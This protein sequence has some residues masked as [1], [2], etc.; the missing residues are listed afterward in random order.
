MAI[1]GYNNNI[2]IIKSAR[3]PSTHKFINNEVNLFSST[4]MYF[5]RLTI[6]AES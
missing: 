1:N 5:A 6:K 3:L 4:E 2:D